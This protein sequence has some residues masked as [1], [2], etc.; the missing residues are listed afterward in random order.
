MKW[1]LY[2][3]KFTLLVSN[4]ENKFLNSEYRPHRANSELIDINKNNKET[5][6]ANESANNT[7]ATTND[8]IKFYSN[9]CLKSK[10]FSQGR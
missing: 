6:I 2:V 5:N 8:I 3:L 9:L 1:N 4:D 7:D 10:T